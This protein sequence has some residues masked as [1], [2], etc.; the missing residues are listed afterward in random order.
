MN[1]A[2]IALRIADF[3]KKYPPFEFL[4]ED[5]LVEL[6]SAGRVK[7]HEVDE[8][9][10]TAGQ[11]RNQFIYVVSQGRV[12]VVGSSSGKQQLV[13]LRGPGE[14]IGLQGLIC[15]SPYFDTGI[16]E[17]DVL[18]YALPRIALAHLIERAP[19]AKRYLAAY[20]SLSASVGRQASA[21]TLDSE[22]SIIPVTL[23]KGGLLE[24]AEPQNVARE[25]LITVP[26]SMPGLQAAKCIDSKRVPCVVVVD[27]HGCPIGKLTDAD[28]R[29]RFIEGRV[30]AQETAA[31]LMHTDLAFAKPWDDTGKLLVRM[32]RAGK[33][34]LIVTEDGTAATPALGLVTERNFFLQYGRFPTLLGEAMSEAPSVAAL[35]SMRNRMEALILEFMDGRE[36]VAWLMEMTGVLNR[37]L[38][39][40][41]LRLTEDAM[42]LEGWVMPSVPFTWLM[43]GSG[44]RDELLIRSAVYHALMY[45]DPAPQD[46]VETGRYF[47]EFARRAADG[48]RQCGFLDSPQGILASRPEWCLPESAMRARYSRMISNPVENMVYTYR[49]AFDFRPIVHRH[50]LA[51][52]LREH[53]HGELGKH[54]EFLRHMAKDS[55]L[56]QPPRTLFKNYVVDEQG[57]QKEELEIKHHALLPLVDTARVL[58]LA[59]RELTTT[60]TFKRL[61]D[62]V[63]FL[64]DLSPSQATLLGEAAQA[65]LVLAYARTQQGLLNGTDGAIIRPADLDAETRPF[66]KTAFRTVLGSLELLAKRYNLEMRS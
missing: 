34:F 1:T 19:R 3:L 39:A 6:A 36:H 61:R 7:F 53:I 37:T 30:L 5:D 41:I 38:T 46:E 35:S 15:D 28:L 45:A 51:V 25:S 58:A 12:R 4:S 32:T 48:I 24:V 40:R 57:E 63:R 14:I 18:L 49:D 17:T 26:G 16:A 33:R 11:P 9:I 43:M 42:S 66:L 59:T 22:R 55:L 44:G 13:D 65:F 20:F 31:T 10:F 56:N 60:S 8:V 27:D 50:P 64:D 47:R 21:V 52:A 54:P 29:E 62:A 2:T 23:R